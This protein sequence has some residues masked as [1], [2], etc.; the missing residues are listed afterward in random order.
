MVTPATYKEGLTS[1]SHFRG[2]YDAVN[3]CGAAEYYDGTVHEY[4]NSM[5]YRFLRLKKTTAKKYSRDV[6]NSLNQ[7]M[8]NVTDY[9]YDDY[10]NLRH[11][12]T[13]DSKGLTLKNSYWYNYMYFNYFD[14]GLRRLLHAC[15]ADGNAQP[16]NAIRGL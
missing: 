15:T 10:H 11:Q 16:S 6:T 12:T 13:T 2:P 1:L 9:E 8:T 4:Y 7:V 5:N 14:A 3:N